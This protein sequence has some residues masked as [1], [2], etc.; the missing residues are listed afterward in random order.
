MSRM[1]SSTGRNVAI[2]LAIW[3]GT[4]IAGSCLGLAI[5]FSGLTFEDW[6]LGGALASPLGLLGAIAFVWRREKKHRRIMLGILFFFLGIQSLVATSA[7]FIDVPLLLKHRERID[8][9]RSLGPGDI[10][11]ME[12]YDDAAREPELLKTIT[13]RDV[14]DT[15]SAAVADLDPWSPQHPDYEGEWYVVLE[16]EKKVELKL[17]LV[18]DAPGTVFGKFVRRRGSRTTYYGGFQSRGLYPWLKQ[19]VQAD[20]ASR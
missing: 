20:A 6:W 2:A 17:Y 14:L 7:L 16:S 8:H 10:A 13:D 12:I 11:R 4:A 5:G 9:M 3:M 18:R 19:V 1:A 15:F